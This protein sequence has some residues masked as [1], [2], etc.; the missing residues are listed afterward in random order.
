MHK[1]TATTITATTAKLINP[2][3]ANCSKLLLFK[4]LSSIL[5]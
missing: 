3:N 5:V 1:T 2:F 4:W